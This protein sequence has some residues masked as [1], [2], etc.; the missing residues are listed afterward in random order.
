VDQTIRAV[1]S[2][3]DHIHSTTSLIHTLGEKSQAISSVSDVIRGIAEQTNLL[4]L[5]AAIEAA[6]AGEQG[7]GFAVVADEVRTLAQRT[8]ESTHSIQKIIQELQ[9]GT[10]A[11]VVAMDSSR[12]QTQEAVTETKET[13]VALDNVLADMNRIFEMSQ[14]IATASEEQSAVSEELSHSIH[15]VNQVATENAT[16]SIQIATESRHLSQLAEKLQ[17]MIAAFKV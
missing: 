8:Q 1:E 2:L 4:A 14:Q 10:A 12:E 11:A 5:N 7:R 3:A 15:K 6:R 13:G 17:S 16:G 9:S